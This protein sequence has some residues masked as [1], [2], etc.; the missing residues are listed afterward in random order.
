[1]RVATVATK[2]CRAALGWRPLRRP[3]ASAADTTFSVALAICS[4]YL[5]CWSRITPRTFIASEGRISLSLTWSGR[6]DTLVAFLEKWMKAV[7]FASNVAPLACSH[8]R[9]LVTIVL[10]QVVIQLCSCSRVAM[11]A[12][13]GIYLSY[14]VRAGAYPSYPSD[15]CLLLKHALPACCSRASSSVS[16]HTDMRI[17][18][19]ELHSS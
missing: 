5:K 14:V 18:S 1:M 4:R 11:P 6:F 16:L 2:S 9:A 15:S 19:L 13:P 10:W 3:R 17:R 7:F 12:Y 8:S